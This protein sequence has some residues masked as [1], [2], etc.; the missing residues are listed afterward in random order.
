MSIEFRSKVKIETIKI[1]LLKLVNRHFVD[2]IFNKLHAQN[3][4]KYITQSISHNYS[5]FVV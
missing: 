4:I 3:R 5:I 2:E 1:Y